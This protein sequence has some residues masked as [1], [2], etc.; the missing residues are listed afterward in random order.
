MLIALL[1]TTLLALYSSS[2]DFKEIVAGEKIRHGLQWLFRAAVVTLVCYLTKCLLFAIPLAFLFSALFRYKLNKKRGLDWRYV[3][4]S[5]HYDWF[6]IR[7]TMGRYTRSEALEDWFILGL[8]QD[9]NR[10]G[11]LAYIFEAI[12]FTAGSILYLLYA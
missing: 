6:F 4:P 10:A 9:A 5:N 1:A 2:D 8:C 3:S 11:L 12:V 7:M